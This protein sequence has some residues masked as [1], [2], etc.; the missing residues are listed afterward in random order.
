MRQAVDSPLWK[1]AEAFYQTLPRPIQRHL[2]EPRYKPDCRDPRMI[3]VDSEFIAGLEA[4]RKKGDTDS[5]AAE[6]AAKILLDKRQ[7]LVD[8]RDKRTV[9]YDE[10]TKRFLAAAGF[11]KIPAWRGRAVAFVQADIA[12][13]VLC[14]FTTTKTFFDTNSGRLCWTG[15]CVTQVIVD[16]IEARRYE[17]NKLATTQFFIGQEGYFLKFAALAVN[18]SGGPRNLMGPHITTHLFD[19]PLNGCARSMMPEPSGIIVDR[20]RNR[21]PIVGYPFSGKQYKLLTGAVEAQL[22]PFDPSAVKSKNPI[23][24]VGWRLEA[25]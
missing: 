20:E 12:E 6:A 10:Q 24:R 17:R 23:A 13:V 25:L 8:R 19:L 11:R 3:D 22:P 14:D 18:V 1:E 4:L 2:G 15:P 5:E 16:G 9:P 21:F 7:V